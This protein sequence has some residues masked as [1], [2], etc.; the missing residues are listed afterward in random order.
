M[1]HAPPAV[2]R[3]PGRRGGVR[4]RIT[5]RD[6]PNETRGGR[7]LAEEIFTDANKAGG[8]VDVCAGGRHPFFAGASSLITGDSEFC[9]KAGRKPAVRRNAG[10]VCV[11][12]RR[13]LRTFTDYRRTRIAP[14]E[15]VIREVFA[16]LGPLW[17]AYHP[18][19]GWQDR[20]HD[21]DA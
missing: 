1:A 20:A 11:D 9:A 5:L 2:G 6:P 17:M 7:A 13:M 15:L 4:R 14:E 3:T 8:G 18:P 21:D 12:M 16:A 19:A 10:Q